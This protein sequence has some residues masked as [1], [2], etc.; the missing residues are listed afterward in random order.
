MLLVTNAAIR[1]VAASI[2]SGIT[3]K[4]SD[5]KLS[6]PSIIIC[7][8]PSPEILAPIAMRNSPKFII[9]GS[10]AELFRIVLP[11]A[12][13]AAIIKFA[14]PVTETGLNSKSQPFSSEATAWI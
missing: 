1:K 10:L 7:S 5:F 6:T 3:L 12:K 8:V 14:V 13:E 4:H 9:S 11:L 2:L